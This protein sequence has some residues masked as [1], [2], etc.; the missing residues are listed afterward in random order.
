MKWLEKVAL[1]SSISSFYR[2]LPIMVSAA[3]DLSTFRAQI[4]KRPIDHH[5][6]QEVVKLLRT[7]GVSVTPS[8]LKARAI[9]SEI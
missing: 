2:I 4:E 6:Q 3:V 9:K 5:T 7:E 8:I 1:T